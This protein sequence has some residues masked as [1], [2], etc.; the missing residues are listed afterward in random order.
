MIQVQVWGAV[1]GGLVIAPELCEVVALEGFG[2]RVKVL[3]ELGGRLIGQIDGQTEEW[4]VV[5]FE[6][7]G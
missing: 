2:E 6:H 3:D 1:V 7:G 5:G 4:Q